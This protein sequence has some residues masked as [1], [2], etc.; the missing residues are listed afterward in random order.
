MP[1]P[2]PKRF[3]DNDRNIIVQ[4]YLAGESRLTIARSLV[5]KPEVITAILTSQGV[6]LRPE[7]TRKIAS[8][9]DALI[10]SRYESGEPVKP[11]MRDYGCSRDTI[12]KILVRH[13]VELRPTGGRSRRF[14]ADELQEME[15][16][17]R[18]GWSQQRIAEYF[19]STQIAISRTMRMHDIQ[20]GWTG[21]RTGGKHHSWRG[22]RTTNEQG[23]VS[24]R[25]PNDSPFISMRNYM[26]YIQEHRLVMAQHLGRPLEKYETV[27]HINGDHS[28]NRI[29]NLQLRVGKH[30][31][32][33][34][35]CCADCGS[36]N[37]VPCELD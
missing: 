37:I 1:R 22:G 9:Q 26:G 16:L 27:H 7:T 33:V 19:R 36:R 6:E 23:Y 11:L 14:T 18:S 10:I 20:P 4:R 15:R 28:D 13:G 12:R 21:A 30:G 32:G 29:E 35:Y 17:A 3:T 5:T 25:V 34:S 8:D 31:K 24:V 2:I